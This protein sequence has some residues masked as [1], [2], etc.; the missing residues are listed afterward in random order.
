MESKLASTYSFTFWLRDSYERSCLTNLISFY[1]KVTHLVDEGKA[2]DVVYLHFSKAFDIISHSILREKS[3]AHSSARRTLCWVTNGLDGRAQRIVVDGVKSSWRRVTSGLPQGSVLG[4]FLFNILIKR[5]DKGI[6]RTLRKLADDTTLGGS[7]DLPEGRRALQR[8]L[9]RLDRWIKANY[10]RFNKA[11]CRALHLG[12]N[13]PGRHYGL[14][15]EWLESCP[16]EKD[17][18]GLAN[19]WLSMSRQRAQ[20]AKAANSIL[21]CISNRVASRTRAAIVTPYSALLETFCYFNPIFVIYPKHK[22]K[23]GR[24][25]IE[26]NPKEV[27]LGDEKLNMSRQCALA[28]QKA[29]RTPLG[30][31]RPA[32]GSPGQ[33][34]HGAVGASPEEAM[35]MI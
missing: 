32:L 21:A 28:A 15:E 24:E 16:A 9:D 1:D 34:G 26:S 30:V 33:E 10:M 14:G 5:L 22:Y 2:V 23:L 18:G 19:S 35:K 3:A 11:Q 12:H 27:V 8:D 29:D 25:W 7:V 6:G 20:M 31:L 13:H 17:L 4:P